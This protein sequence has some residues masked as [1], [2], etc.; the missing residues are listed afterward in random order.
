[1]NEIQGQMDQ[2]R[3]LVNEPWKHYQLRQNG[4][5]FSQ[6]VS[7][8]DTVE[9]T[10]EAISAFEEESEMQSPRKL[11]LLI[12]GVLQACFLQQDA[13]NHLCEALGLQASLAKYPALAAVREIRNDSV[14]HPTKR[15]GRKGKLT[16]YHQISRATMSKGRFKMLS[17][18]SDGSRNFRD[19]SIPDI[20]AD[21]KKFVGEVLNEVIAALQ[22]EK[23]AHKEKFRME[24][25]VDV[26]PQTLTYAFEKAANALYSEPI[27]LGHWGLETIT[28][29]LHSFHEAVGRR[30]ME[31]YT[32]LKD[33]YNYIDH[34]VG[35]LGSIFDARK[36]GT[37][38]SDNERD[39]HIYL[40]FLRQQVDAMQKLAEEIDEDY[41][42]D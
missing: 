36:N 2:I 35:R 3:D 9:D 41:G 32:S 20:I 11:Y 39:G 15:G 38:Q 17:H 31:L 7:A 42:S 5:L 37:Q 30:D 28:D 14:G 24:K 25:L 8:L 33:D 16:S 12:Y 18:Y 27:E 23:K 1:M 26:F 21:Q 4:T 6:L 40:S 22:A 29:S 34:A 19:I 10:D 13:T